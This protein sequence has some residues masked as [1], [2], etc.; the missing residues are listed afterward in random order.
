MFE[1]FP[2]FTRASGLIETLELSDRIARSEKR[3]AARSGKL[4]AW[5]DLWSAL[6]SDN[7]DLRDYAKGYVRGLTGKHREA[8]QHYAMRRLRKPDYRAA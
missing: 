3:L 7:R 4:L 2:E 1:Q 6:L 8:W 5:S